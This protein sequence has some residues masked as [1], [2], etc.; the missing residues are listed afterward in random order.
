MIARSLAH[1]YPIVVCDEHQDSSAD[2]HAITMACHNAGAAVRIF[3]DPMQRIYGSRK[4]AEIEECNRRWESLKAT[5]GVFD[6][7]DYP[8]RWSGER[9]L[10]GRWILT[11]RTALCAG[12]QIDLR[13]PL[14]SSVSV[15]F[16]EN[17][18]PRRGGYSLATS[19][20]RPIYDLVRTKESILVLAAHKSTVDSLRAFFGR[21]LPIWEGHVRDGLST[22]VGAT[23]K[24]KGDAST[25]AQIVVKFISHVATG[26]SPSCYAKDLLAEVSSGCVRRR[27]GRAATLQALGRVILD[28]PDHKGAAK[29]LSRLHELTTV[30]PAFRAVK[31]DY[32]REFWEAVRIGQ[33]DDPLEGFAEISR[34]RSYARPLPPTKAISTV[35]KAK[36]LE[37]SDVLIIPC[38]AGHFGNSPAARCRLYVAMSRATRSLT[39]VVSRRNPSPLVVV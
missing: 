34:R 36:G 1:R 29:L 15:I 25:I 3:G 2:Q 13:G 32:H 39:L 28:Q 33:F 31:L 16:A 27:S 14:P 21:R 6:E 10:L 8:H 5:A 26:F 37:C 12:G 7:L 22:L 9:A 30:D 19:D 38:D 4:K 17:Q 23:Q 20:S 24:H 11:A 35:H 18:S